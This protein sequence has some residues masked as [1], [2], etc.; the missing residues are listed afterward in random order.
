MVCDRNGSDTMKIRQ[1]FLL[2][3]IANQTYLVDYTREQAVLHSLNETGA[4]LCALLT[5]GPDVAELKDKILEEYQAEE[6]EVERD[7]AEFVQMLRQ[8]GALEE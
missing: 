7:I 6:A 5:S 3:K 4:L 8:I 1:G 2:K